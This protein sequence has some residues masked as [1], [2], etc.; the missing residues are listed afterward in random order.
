MLT[1]NVAIAT[2]RQKVTLGTS[3]MQCSPMLFV[4]GPVHCS[5][6]LFIHTLYTLPGER[7]LRT[8]SHNVTMQFHWGIN[9]Y[10]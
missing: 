3:L 6:V 8:F 2:L 9:I 4:Q 5:C 7:E 10:L 1:T